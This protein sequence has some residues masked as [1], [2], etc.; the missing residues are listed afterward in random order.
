M[1][2]LFAHISVSLDGYITDVEGDDGFFPLDDSFHQHIE[3]MV[4]ELGGMVFGRRAYE[5]LATFWPTAGASGDESLARQAV[6]MNTLPKYVLTHSPLTTK[7]EQAS[8]VSLSELATLKAR[9]VKPIAVFAGAAAIQS[10]LK[11]DLLDE[12]QLLR[13]PVILGGGVPLFDRGMAPQKLRLTSTKT[14][15]TGAILEAYRPMEPAHA[16]ERT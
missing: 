10:V 13:Q 1:A 16:G 12:L 4:S 8:P 5:L 11:A 2:R 9:E 15:S 3:N 7:W 14:L 6:H